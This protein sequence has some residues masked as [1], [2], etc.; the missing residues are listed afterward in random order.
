MNIAKLFISIIIAVIFASVFLVSFPTFNTLFRSTEMYGTFTNDTGVAT[1]SPISLVSG[2][3]TIAVTNIGQFTVFL[4]S[5]TAIAASS[6]GTVQ[7]SPVTLTE[8]SNT[9][10]V[11]VVGNITVTVTGMTPITG[12]IV[13]FL[14][15]ALVL[16]GILIVIIIVQSR[17]QE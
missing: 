12:F 5:G 6:T 3:N 16:G 15:Y 9:I 2:T 4:E 8:G 11:T 14:P 13:R 17:R 7:G 10:N 1:G